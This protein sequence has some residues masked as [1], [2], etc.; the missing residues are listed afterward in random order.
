MSFVQYILIPS[1]IIVVLIALNALFVA[2]EFA[3]IGVRRSRIEQLV[4]EGNR[5]ASW[6]A[7]NLANPGAMDRYIATAQL[8]ITL[9][10]LG[11]G[12]YAEP[13][14]AHLIEPPLH[15][16][17]GLEGA[18]VHTLSFTIALSFITYLHVVAGEMVPKSL[19]LQDAERMVLL[20][21]LPMRLIERLFYIPV[22]VLNYI[23]VLVIRMVGI[24]PVRE[25]A[26]LYSPD[27]LEY[28]VSES[29]TVG[30]LEE[31]EQELVANIFDFT[32]RRVVHVM[33]PRPKMTAIPLDISAEDLRTF[34]T[35]TPHTRLPVYQDRIDRILG[36]LHLKDYVRQQ[37]SGDPFD[38]RAII[39]A[40]P[41][42][43][44]LQYA[45][46]VLETFRTMHQHMAIV[47]D[48]HGSVVGLVTLE[49]LLEEVVG[50]VR[51]EFDTGEGEPLQMIAPGQYLVDGTLSLLDLSDELGIDVGDQDVTTIGGLVM[52]LLG[53][54]AEVGDSIETED[55]RCIVEALDGLAITRVRVFVKRSGGSTE[56]E[57]S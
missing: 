10:S 2:A 30:L 3:I 40:V 14:I 11:L 18:I 46:R 19:S 6:V 52:A 1:V 17:F 54:M 16:I 4:R 8:G 7:A 42:V 25:G 36:V 48:E 39:R 33:T 38:L 21:A 34:F 50:E 5:S 12:M 44:E 23:G 37:L 20:L 29:A 13:A 27:E 35:E 28:I 51:D 45:V 49:D 15:D 56:G 9:A 32:E 26:R 55:F 41:F 43:L 57:A 31:R 24:A 22:R 53:R 47:M